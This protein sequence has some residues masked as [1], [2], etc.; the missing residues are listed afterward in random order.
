[1]EIRS[2][3]SAIGLTVREGDDELQESGSW[4]W[5]DTGVEGVRTHTT[6]CVYITV[7]TA[8]LVLPTM[9][10]KKQSEW[11]G[12]LFFLSSVERKVVFFDANVVGMHAWWRH[13]L[14]GNQNYQSMDPPQPHEPPKRKNRKLVVAQ[15]RVLQTEIL[16]LSC[17]IAACAVHREPC[18]PTISSSLEMDR[19][20]RRRASC[21]VVT[22]TSSSHSCVEPSSPSVVLP[23]ERRGSSSSPNN[24]KMWLLKQDIRAHEEQIQSILQ[25]M[26]S[27]S[28]TNNNNHIAKEE[29]Y[30]DRTR[31][32]SEG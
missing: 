3:Q 13:T 9:E 17:Q 26:I 30:D 1:M 27:S 16:E 18:L 20:R 29:G 10:R 2:S 11:C 7:G 23:E 25:N 22:S 8:P 4:T 14:F 24:H 21:G 12:T 15:L 5:N 31:K 32:L 28:G 19:G 6:V